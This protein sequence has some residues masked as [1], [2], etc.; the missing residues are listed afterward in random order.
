VSESEP[1]IMDNI[2]YSVVV[3]ELCIVRRGCVC[4]EI[5]GLEL[6]MVHRCVKGRKRL[7]L[8]FC[9]RSCSE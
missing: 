7:L 5:L 4:F 9:D 8:Y 3:L 2:F 6:S 1:P